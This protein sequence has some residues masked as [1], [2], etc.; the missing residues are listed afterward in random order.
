M[1]GKETRKEK[2]ICYAKHN[3]TKQCPNQMKR[4]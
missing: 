4:H 1:K 3:M 2:N